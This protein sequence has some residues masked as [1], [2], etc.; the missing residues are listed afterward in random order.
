MATGSRSGNIPSNLETVNQENDIVSDSDISNDSLEELDLDSLKKEQSRIDSVLNYLVNFNCPK[1]KVGRPKKTAR[2]R[3]KQTASTS[4][5][6]SSNIQ[7]LEVGTDENI[8]EI[9]SINP[10]MLMEYL[11][12]INEFNKK[13]LKGISTLS[14]KYDDLAGQVRQ[15]SEPSSRIEEQPPNPQPPRTNVNK[16]QIDS[17]LEVRV[18]AIEQRENANI[19]LCSGSVI[20]NAI[21]GPQESLKDNIVARI[22]EL[23]PEV[24]GDEI[25]RVVPFGNKKTHV[26]VECSSLKNKRKILTLVRQKKPVGLYF[27]EF[28]TQYRSKM[29]YSLRSL[30]VKF[31]NKIKSVYTRDGNLFYKMCD[32]DDFRRIRS[33]IDITELEKRLNETEE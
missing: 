22:K 17:D 15:V 12:S 4:R 25:L 6:D 3:G 24:D 31:P 16:S 20:K 7:R 11:T 13:L 30:K 23:I 2:G 5:Q 1:K 27:S 32:S 33:P 28:L 29:F 18:D 26:K 14:K 19:L 21:E 9:G 8:P 10:N